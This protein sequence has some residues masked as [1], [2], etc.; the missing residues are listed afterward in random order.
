[1][2]SKHPLFPEDTVDKISDFLER[3]YRFMIELSENQRLWTG[4]SKFF[5]IISKLITIAAIVILV[6]NAIYLLPNK[7]YLELWNVIPLFSNI[8]K[9]E[10]WLLIGGVCSTLYAMLLFF[11]LIGRLIHIILRFIA[12]SFEVLISQPLRNLGKALIDLITNNGIWIFLRRLGRTIGYK[13]FIY[14]LLLYLE[15]GLDRKT[16]N[17]DSVNQ[18]PP[19]A[20][21]DKP[22]CEDVIER[23]NQFGGLGILFIYIAFF[24]AFFILDTVTKPIYFLFSLLPIPLN[25]ILTQVIAIGELGFLISILFFSVT[26]Y[27]ERRQAWVICFN[28]HYLRAYIEAAAR[29]VGSD[30]DSKLRLGIENLNNQYM[31]D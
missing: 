23:Y 6:A 3:A 4:I 7:H 29:E 24:L 8:S 11:I 16:L 27:L 25:T 12:H 28:Q 15:P 13:Y 20:Y 30:I 19:K 17:I 2:N 14:P 21:A 10:S 22:Y 18:L 1:M 9:Q 26:P 31:N 5:R